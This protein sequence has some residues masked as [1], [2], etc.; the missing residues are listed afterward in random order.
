MLIAGARLVGRLPLLF[1]EN[2]KKVPWFEKKD[3]D[4]VQFW[5][6]FSIR[7]VVLRV[8]RGK[9]SKRFSYR[10]FFSCIL[11]KCLSK[12]PNSTKL[13]LSWKIL[14]LCLSW[15]R[16]AFLVQPLDIRINTTEEFGECF[17]SCH[18]FFWFV[19]LMWTYWSVIIIYG[20]INSSFF[21]YV[22]TTHDTTT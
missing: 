15:N 3:P 18:H 22:F 14:V 6:K 21:S 20:L 17:F 2:Q 9:N 4:S 8:S 12:C 13:P 16:D 10:V 7:N 1:F 11:T 5:V 19:T